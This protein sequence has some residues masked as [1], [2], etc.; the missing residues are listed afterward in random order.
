MITRQHLIQLVPTL[1]F[2]TAFCCGAVLEGIAQLNH[3]QV[4]FV[5]GVEVVALVVLF[6]SVFHFAAARFGST[7]AF[8]SIM[9]T[10]LVCDLG[11]GTLMA[12]NR[13]ASYASPPLIL[14]IP[15][16]GLVGI[17]VLLFVF[18]LT[19]SVVTLVYYVVS[20]CI[21]LLRPKREAALR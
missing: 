21:F 7:T 8:V 2:T 19:G 10:C 11:A 20:G 5:F 13:S 9:L 18:P 4:G 6:W 3:R 1:Q 12:V 15:A 16:L 14:Q 17:F